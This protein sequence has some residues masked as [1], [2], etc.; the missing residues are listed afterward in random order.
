MEGQI[1]LN[2]TNKKANDKE[3]QASEQQIS[4][5]IFKYFKPTPDPTLVLEPHKDKNLSSEL[6]EL[7][8]NQVKRTSSIYKYY[9]KIGFQVFIYL[10]NILEVIFILV[11]DSY[12]NYGHTLSP[13]IL[14][15]YC[16]V[17][18]FI[19]ELGC[20]L[21][22][23]GKLKNKSFVLIFQTI[24][25]I[26]L[27][28]HQVILK[29]LHLFIISTEINQQNSFHLVRLINTCNQVVKINLEIHV[30]FQ[31]KNKTCKYI[32]GFNIPQ[33]CFSLN[34]DYNDNSNY[35]L[36][37]YIRL[38]QHSS[39]KMGWIQCDQ[40]FIINKQFNLLLYEII[41][42]CIYQNLQINATEVQFK[43]KKIK[44]KFIQET[45]SLLKADLKYI[46]FVQSFI[47]IFIQINSVLIKRRDA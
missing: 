19:V 6:Q 27:W 23:S 29:Q 12:M 2:S 11:Y 7:I 9:A 21:I 38:L 5:S 40:F 10:L 35:S 44:L 33:S 8:E 28:E 3:Q 20:T 32:Q 17:L 34:D 39:R 1:P 15:L 30:C 31:R 43:L 47:F 4:F 25:T 24:Y 14:F 37:L 45:K 46:E 42:Y 22:Y 18:Y 16:F 41:I 13:S 26:F 36:N